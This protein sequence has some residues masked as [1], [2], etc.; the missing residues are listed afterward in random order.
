MTD[1]VA[2]AL[3]GAF[4]RMGLEIAKTAASFPGVR[5]TAALER[6]PGLFVRDG[7]G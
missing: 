1:P 7:F 5:I 6:G 3:V 4:G 2:V